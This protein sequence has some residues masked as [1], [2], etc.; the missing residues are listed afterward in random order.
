MEDKEIVEL[1][2]QRS[3]NAIE[4]TKN[5]YDKYCYRIAYNILYNNEDSEECV[6][7]T[8]MKAWNAIPPTKPLKLSAFLGKITRNLALHVHK[9]KHSLKRGEGQVHAVYEELQEVISNHDNPEEKVQVD[10]VASCITTYLKTLP[11]QQRMVFVGRYW[12]FESIEE[13]AKRLGIT[14][15]KTKTILFR[16]RNGLKEYLAKE[17]ILV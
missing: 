13:I 4:E 12:G 1:Y 11:K 8:Y 15:G 2:F 6:N 5:K 7:D 17:G 3:E 10:F 9:K 16:T 14:K